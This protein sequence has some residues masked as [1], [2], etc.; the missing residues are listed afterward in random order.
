[1][2]VIAEVAAFIHTLYGFGNQPANPNDLAGFQPR[3][4]ERPDTEK[5]I[6][7]TQKRHRR[8]FKNGSRMGKFDTTRKANA[9]D[10]RGYRSEK[11]Q[12]GDRDGDMHPQHAFFRVGGIG[13]NAKEDEK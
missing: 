3:I 1:M 2:G 11:S 4:D 13:H 6:N 10:V 12:Q 8:F 7:E 9:I 5:H